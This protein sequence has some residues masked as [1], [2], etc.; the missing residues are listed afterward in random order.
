M[1]MWH[2]YEP[3]RTNKNKNIN[4]LWKHVPEFE[5]KKKRIF[6]VE[7]KHI[8]VYTDKWEIFSKW[9]KWYLAQNYC[10]MCISN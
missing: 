2:L 4:Y 10:Y 9:L 8:G 6:K 1:V 3:V 5:I 7:N